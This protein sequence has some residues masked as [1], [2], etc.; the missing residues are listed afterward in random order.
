MKKKQ[1]ASSNRL[2]FPNIVMGA[3]CYD[4][5]I[6]VK[7][8]TKLYD[9]NHRHGITLYDGNHRHGIAIHDG[10]HRHDKAAP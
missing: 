4:G 1:Q 7:I 8:A 5:R 9:G 2:L 6:I 3:K 10:N